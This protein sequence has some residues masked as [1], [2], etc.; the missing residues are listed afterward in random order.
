LVEQVLGYLT[1]R[2]SFP[3]EDGVYRLPLAG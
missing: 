1:E 3:V 2:Q